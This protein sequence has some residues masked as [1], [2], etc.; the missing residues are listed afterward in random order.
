MECLERLHS[1]LYGKYKEFA[2]ENS[3]LKEKIVRPSALIKEQNS[4]KIAKN[5][6][7]DGDSPEKVARNTGL[8][9][10]KA[11]AL[12]KSTKKTKIPA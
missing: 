8:P 5:M 3:M 6:I 9:L 10:A 11:K 7:A 1:E 12:L 2:E 4:L